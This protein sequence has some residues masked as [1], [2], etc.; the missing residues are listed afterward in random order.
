MVDYFASDKR[1]T[2]WKRGLREV[3]ES[4]NARVQ[5]CEE[6]HSRY[7]IFWEKPVS[8]DA[9]ARVL[10]LAKRASSTFAILGVPRGLS[11]DAAADA[12]GLQQAPLAL[13]SVQAETTE[14][15]KRRRLS[16][17][18]PVP[19]SGRTSASQAAPVSGQSVLPLHLLPMK[20]AE[21]ILPS[22]SR[23]LDVQETKYTID[24][25]T[26]LGSGSFGSVHG[27]TAPFC[28]QQLAIKM[29]APRA[30]ANLLA[31]SAEKEVVRLAA[32]GRHCNIVGLLDVAVFQVPNE[33]RTLGL[34]FER[35]A[36]DLG[37]T[38][39]IM[40]VR[41]TGQRHVLRSVLEAVTYMH[42]KG[43]V[44]ADVKSPNVLLRGRGRFQRIWCEMLA[45]CAA[46]ASKAASA[47]EATAA[48]MTNHL[49][50]AFEVRGPLGGGR[51]RLRLNPPALK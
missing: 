46:S 33:A 23:S 1:A 12:D 4:Q 40:A 36:A 38:L 18:T 37:Q 3:V 10:T 42:A 14:E 29:F 50:Q 39:K 32:L 7:I 44:H 19:A 45:G 24:W 34:D 49:P 5:L 27:A 47:K 15:P 22:F 9:A 20:M 43:I 8:Y 30:N 51:N 13:D 2:G 26:A 35:Y 28:T 11:D 31:A 41:S 25:A 21:N 17:K 16:A 6:S 48:E